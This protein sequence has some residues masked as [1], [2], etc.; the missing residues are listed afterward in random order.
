MITKL[1]PLQQEVKSSNTSLLKGG[2]PSNILLMVAV[3]QTLID[4]LLI[5]G[6]LILLLSSTNVINLSAKT[7]VHFQALFYI[8]AIVISLRLPT[9]LVRHAVKSSI[10]EAMESFGG[11]NISKQT[12]NISKQAS[13][14]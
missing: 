14:N 11:T 5:L 7:A 13:K 3:N 4:V 6:F 1:T 10:M 2:S 12:S 9:V 8:L